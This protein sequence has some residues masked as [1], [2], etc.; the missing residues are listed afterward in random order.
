M[1]CSSCDDGRP[2]GW[3]GGIDSDPAELEEGF[4]LPF[5]RARLGPEPAGE[6]PDLRE[7]VGIDRGAELNVPAG[8]GV[9]FG[10]RLFLGVLLLA[11]LGTIYGNVG[12]SSHYLGPSL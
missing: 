3:G 6:D 8:L 4:I 10:L 12:F 7:G 1:R 2:A 5:F 11:G 9:L